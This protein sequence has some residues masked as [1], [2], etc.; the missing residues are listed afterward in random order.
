[1]AFP[2]VTLY[3]WLYVFH[4]DLSNQ[5][6][7]ES[8]EEDRMNKPWRAIPS[9]RLTVEDAEKWYLVATALLLIATGTWLGGFPEALAFMVE[10]WVYDSAAGASSWWAKNIINALFYSTG[11]L[12]AT[13]VA[14]QFGMGC[15]ITR[16]GLEWCALLCLMTLTTVQIQD[17]RDQEGDGARGRKTMPLAIGDGPCRWLTAF[18]ILFWSVACPFYWAGTRISAAY[19]PPV[20]VG[21][22]I[23]AR[24]LRHRNVADD[25][26]SFHYHTLVWLPVLYSVPLLSK[27]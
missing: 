4:F 23:A 20:L 26:K 21:G 19:V 2:P 6:S 1:M 15:E 18:F 22:M 27:I 7:P 9:G 14:A 17:L 25:R 5:K 3:V 24:I 13:R 8:I 12:G 10:T 11:Q 16:A